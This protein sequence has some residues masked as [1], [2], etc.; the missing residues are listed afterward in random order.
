MEKH[1]TQSTETNR[2]WERNRANE[3]ETSQG[4]SQEG[5]TSGQDG[6]WPTEVRGEVGILKKGK[7]KK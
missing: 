5:N 3:G 7:T 2:H 4:H 1:T 6:K